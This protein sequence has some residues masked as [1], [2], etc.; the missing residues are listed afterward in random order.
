MKLNSNVLSERSRLER[1]V[2]LQSIEEKRKLL[3]KGSIYQ[4]CCRTLTFFF[5][6]RRLL[7]IRSGKWQQHINMQMKECGW[8]SDGKGFLWWQLSGSTFCGMASEPKKRRRKRSEMNEEWK[9]AIKIYSPFRSLDRRHHAAAMSTPCRPF[10][11]A[12][13]D[14]KGFRKHKQSINHNSCS[15][16][17]GKQTVIWLENSMRAVITFE[18]CRDK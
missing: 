9:F 11:A 2:A 6:G 10:F 12:K 14:A 8:R 4:K 17:S 13:S 5:V 18:P 15:R 16:Q 7:T 1:R 3:V